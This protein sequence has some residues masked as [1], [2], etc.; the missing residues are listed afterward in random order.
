[1]SEHGIT[2]RYESFIAQGK[3]EFVT[4]PDEVKRCLRLI[5]QHYGYDDYP[6]D[7]C[8]GL[9]HLKVGKIIIHNI[10][11]KRNLA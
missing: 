9:A 10:T 1:M 2:T 6:L 7:R 11:G 3:C 5:N 4:N 8:N